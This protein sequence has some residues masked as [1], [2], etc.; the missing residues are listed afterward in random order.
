MGSTCSHDLEFENDAWRGMFIQTT[1]AYL[2]PIRR[3]WMR[4]IP[5][6][7][8]PCFPSSTTL[9]TSLTWLLS[10]TSISNL[11]QFQVGNAK[12]H[13]IGTYV[14]YLC[15][16]GSDLKKMHEPRMATTSAQTEDTLIMLILS[17]VHRSCCGLLR[18]VA[19]HHL[20]LSHWPNLYSSPLTPNR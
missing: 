15:R 5:I 3:M 8:R 9:C 4:T 1:S 16:Q 10:I 17:L 7:I 12:P 14:G 6:E 20:N 18:M 13:L 11:A 19:H 2:A